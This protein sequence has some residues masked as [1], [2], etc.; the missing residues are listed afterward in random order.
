MF[1][2]SFLGAPVLPP[3]QQ[4]QASFFSAL[5]SA[6][7]VARLRYWNCELGFGWELFFFAVLGETY[8]GWS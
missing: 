4:A 6:G 2:A 3:P 1:P 5:S 8:F 7:E